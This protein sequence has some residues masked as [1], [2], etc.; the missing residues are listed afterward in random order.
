MAVTS[1]WDRLV[2]LFTEPVASKAMVVVQ[3]APWDIG[4]IASE[5][6][7]EFVR[8]ADGER[9]AEQL[10]AADLLLLVQELAFMTDHLD[11]MA[12]DQASD[13]RRWPGPQSPDVLAWKERLARYE[14]VI[15]RCF[16]EDRHDDPACVYDD[17][18]SP[19]LLG[20]YP[21]GNGGWI[22]R[23]ADVTFVYRW[24][25]GLDVDAQ[26][27]TELGPWSIFG[28]LWEATKGKSV[29]A[30][31][32]LK[33]AAL[34]TIENARDYMNWQKKMLP[35]VLVAAS[36]LGVVYLS[37]RYNPRRSS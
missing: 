32:I 31:G 34:E 21:D 2:D 4:K 8:A 24:M 11:V 27:K 9:I 30:G 20:Y 3:K 12:T 25:N 26:T 17:V 5:F 14:Q 13:L 10:T 15:E 1:Y 6:Q 36:V 23:P 33:D 29:E 19:L 18:V 35:Y 16:A 37:A 22:R 28:L 7:R